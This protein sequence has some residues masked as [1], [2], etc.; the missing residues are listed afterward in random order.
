MIKREESV[1]LM[2]HGRQLQRRIV[3]L[4]C[5]LGSIRLG[6]VGE[7]CGCEWAQPS[8]ARLSD[9]ARCADMQLRVQ[10]GTKNEKTK[11]R[12]L[13]GAKIRKDRDTQKEMKSFLQTQNETGKFE[14]E[15]KKTMVQEQFRK[16]ATGLRK[17]H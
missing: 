17:G 7:F 12:K 2:T 16:G 13:T 4:A 5:M 14:T 1:Y 11:K 8:P 10:K 6:S 15:G 9:P 3:P